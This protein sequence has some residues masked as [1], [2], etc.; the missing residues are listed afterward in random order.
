VY[1]SSKQY[2]HLAIDHF[3][4]YIWTISSKTQTS[5]DFSIKSKEFINFLSKQDVKVMFATTN[6]PQS[7]Q[8]IVTSL[9]RI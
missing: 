6:C 8:T 1:N 3:T 5:K 2:I 7:N 4:R 9:R